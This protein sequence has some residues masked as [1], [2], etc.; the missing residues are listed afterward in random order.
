MGP[1]SR[2]LVNISLCRLSGGYSY[3]YNLQSAEVKTFS[4]TRSISYV[5]N[6]FWLAF[7]HWPPTFM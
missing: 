4:F 5:S 2:G 7:R 6:V 1:G 3:R